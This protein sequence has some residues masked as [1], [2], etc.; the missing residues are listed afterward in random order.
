MDLISATSVIDLLL[1]EII[2]LKKRNWKPSEFE[3]VVLVKDRVKVFIKVMQNK[4]YLAI[5]L[6]SN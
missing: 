4:V 3:Q 2:F 6:L 1:N 5:C